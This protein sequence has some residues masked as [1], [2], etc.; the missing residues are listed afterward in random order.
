MKIFGLAAISSVFCASSEKQAILDRF[1][2]SAKGSFRQVDNVT[3][4]TSPG[5]KFKFQLGSYVDVPRLVQ[6]FQIVSGFLENAIE[7]QNGVTV[8]VNYGDFCRP[9]SICKRH[10]PG[11]LI[12]LCKPTTSQLNSSAGP[13]LV[14]HA[15]IRQKTPAANLAEELDVRMYI[16]D[17]PFVFPDQYGDK[18]EEIRND[19]MD[20]IIHELI[21][22]LGLGSSIISEL[23]KCIGKKVDCSNAKFTRSL[24][25]TF[26][27]TNDTTF[28]H[29]LNSTD[30][31]SRAPKYVDL[32]MQLVHSKYIKFLELLRV[33]KYSFFL[34]KNNNKV[35]LNT[36]SAGGGDFSHLERTYNA[37]A[38]YLMTYSSDYYGAFKPH[39][40][41]DK[42]WKTSPL[43][44][45]TIQV[46]ETLGYARNPNPEFE[47]SQ[48]FFY[49]LMSA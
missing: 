47:K 17:M 44:E 1:A 10:A 25:D 11:G 27:Q 41:K 13:V 39:S 4:F 42:D 28:S 38:D 46:L 30:I 15:L 29:L 8:Q 34:T 16:K 35:Y 21:H 24:F 33:E 31:D 2:G 6:A 14:P 19:I 36:I 49:A 7:L 45:T 32:G 23:K 48:A 12:G 18:I 37:T 3:Y 9:N 43:G 40:A 22:G 26:L 5:G 20:L